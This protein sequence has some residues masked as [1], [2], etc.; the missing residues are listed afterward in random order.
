[1]KDNVDDIIL[2][3]RCFSIFV[4]CLGVEI[5]GHQFEKHIMEQIYSNSLRKAFTRDSLEGFR[6][7]I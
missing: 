7:K 1:M 3:L 5:V 2:I 6:K 4:P